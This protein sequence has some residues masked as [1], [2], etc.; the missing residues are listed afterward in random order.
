VEFIPEGSLKKFLLPNIF[1]KAGLVLAIAGII[2]TYLRFGAGI[3]PGFLDTSVFAFYSSYFDTKYFQVIQ[4]NISEE[5]CGITMLAGFFFIAFSREKNEMD[6]YWNY[7]L[8][9]LLLSIYLSMAYL[10]IS[11]F[12]VFGL[13]FF[14]LLS[15]YIILP[16]LLYSLLF[17]YYLLKERFSK[18]D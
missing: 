11:F 2:F 4:N 15:L 13:A 6:H 10:M 5:I 17:R 1:Q 7:R 3:K 16:L 8:K 14:N 9:A 12:F 18:A